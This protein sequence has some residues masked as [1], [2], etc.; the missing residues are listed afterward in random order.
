MS[1]LIGVPADYSA[2][3]RRAMNSLFKAFENFSEGTLI[4]DSDARIVWISER[5]A[6]RFGFTDTRQAIGLDCE[7]VIPNSLMREVVQTGKPI[8]LDVLENGREPLVVTRLPL[9]DETGKTVGAVGFALFDEMK[10]L[11][12]LFSHYSRVQAELIAARQSLAQARRAKYTLASFVGTSAASL[13]VKRQARRAASVDSPVLV[14]GETG[15]GK[16]LLAHAIHGTSSRASGPLVTVNVA[17]IPDTLLEAEFFGADPGAYTGAQRRGRAGKFEL[18]HGGTLF[19]D[20]IGDM[21][22]QLQGKLLRVLQDQ[23]FEPLGSNRIVRTDVRIV[24]A[25]SADLPALVAAGRFRADLFYRL[26]VLTIHAPPLRSRRSDIEALAYA[27]LEELCA[28]GRGGHGRHFEL[29]D[30]ALRLLASHEWPGNVR[31][32]RNALERAVMLSDTER[33]DARTLAAFIGTVVQ[34]MPGGVHDG[35]ARA[36]HADAHAG[37]SDSYGQAM[38]DFERRF[39]GDAL[40]ATGGHVA[41]AAARIGMGRATLYKK[42]AALGIDI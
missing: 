36:S 16:E 26:N 21:P 28:P 13:E 32:L 27:I 6:A 18:A 4:V 31:E 2:I 11:T 23:E 1:D 35:D 17:A 19:L 30:D 10:S 40:R 7:A 33:I 22:L 14:L 34:P 5:Y 12:P 29:Q 24:A 39:L 15:T 8:L 25:T 41:E 20:E 38:A 42:I 37:R 9:E 3:V